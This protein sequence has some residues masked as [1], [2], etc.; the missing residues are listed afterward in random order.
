LAES[1]PIAEMRQYIAERL[2][3]RETAAE[4]ATRIRRH[5]LEDNPELYESWIAFVIDHAM[6]DLVGSVI[7]TQRAMARQQK[8]TEVFERIR[9]QMEAH[10]DATPE[11]RRG[12]VRNARAWLDVQYALRGGQRARLYDMTGAE[13][14]YVAGTYRERATANYI[15]YQWLNAIAQHVG[16]RKVG[17]VYT[18]DQLMSLRLSIGTSPLA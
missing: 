13:C 4:T 10:P 1:D 2:V 17:E 16:N 15:E 12:I 5:I 8:S 7:R 6:T 11:E 14:D 3:N 9:E 18:E